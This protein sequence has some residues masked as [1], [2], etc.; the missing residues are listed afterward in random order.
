M[1]DK[2]SV[3]LQWTGSGIKF[4]GSGE[5]PLSP[6]VLIDG[7]NETGASPMQYLLFAAGAC[8]AADVVLIL[9]KMRVELKKTEV[10]V[11]GVRR[12]EDPKRFVSVHLAFALAGEGLDQSK[13][14]RAVS[15]SVDQY[16]SV[17][18]TLAADLD[19]S[20]EIVLD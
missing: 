9:Q 12:E 16:C 14:E 17:L 6:E 19:V 11:E 3:T 13:A 1:S 15:L 5:E 2:R 20:T 8:A 7:D 10:R 18:H 4:R